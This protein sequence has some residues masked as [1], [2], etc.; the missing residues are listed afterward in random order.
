MQILWKTS[1][2]LVVLFSN[3]A[4]RFA[5][6]GQLGSEG[7]NTTKW[8]RNKLENLKNI[9]QLFAKK[10]III[11]LEEKTSE[12]KKE[13]SCFAAKKVFNFNKITSCLAKNKSIKCETDISGKAL[14]SSKVPVLQTFANNLMQP[15]AQD[16]HL[17]AENETEVTG[18]NRCFFSKL[19]RTMLK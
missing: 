15:N 1:I 8:F 7:F 5:P 10:V 16:K 14:S 6:V 2:H 9:A 17:D 12:F 19:Q 13:K 3:F 11:V 4:V 18:Q